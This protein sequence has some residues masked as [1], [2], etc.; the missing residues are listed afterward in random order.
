M[1]TQGRRICIGRCWI[2]VLSSG[3]TEEDQLRAAVHAHHVGEKL[4]GEAVSQVELV[5]A[6]EKA[7]AEVV[8]EWES[9][10]EMIQRAGW[11]TDCVVF[12]AD[13]WRLHDQSSCKSSEFVLTRPQSNGEDQTASWKLHGRALLP[14]SQSRHITLY[15]HTLAA[16]CDALLPRGYPESVA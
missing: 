15:D 4:K 11:R 12:G 6:I 3:R 5:E 10:R 7:H 9:L 13:G 8:T 16:S 2:Q 14:V 1:G